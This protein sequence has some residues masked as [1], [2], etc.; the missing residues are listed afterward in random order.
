MAMLE[1][2]DL[3]ASLGGDD[4]YA[5]Y[6]TLREAAP[7]HAFGDGM[8]GVTRYDDVYECLRDPATFSSELDLGT[9][10]DGVRIIIATDPPDHTRLRQLV[11]GPFRPAAIAALE[12]RVRAIAESLVDELVAAGERGDADLAAVVADALPVIVIAEMLGVPTDRRV[13]FRT[14]SDASLGLSDEMNEEEARA[15]MLEYFAEAVRE[16][17]Q[18]PRDDLITALVSGKE[19][20]TEEEVLWFCMTLLVAGNETTTNLIG[21]AVLAFFDHPDEAARVWAN[22]ALVPSAMEEVL[23]FDPPAQM[24]ARTV[25]RDATVAGQEIP[26]G[27]F[28]LL[29]LAS[30]NRDPAHYDDPDRFDVT[31]NPRDHMTFGNGVH[32]CLG[33]SLAR[34]EARLAFETLIE[35]VRDLRPNGTPERN[36]N[37]MLRGVKHLPVTFS[38][39]N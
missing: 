34:L 32:L 20:L 38:A 37:Q 5:H 35:R 19:Q 10:T 28:V 36:S 26:A 23:R 27:S 14:W 12:P 3:F 15:A 33:A 13:D 16:R 9:A 22:P 1:M 4:P 29:M 2:A 7:V 17:R 11:T 31:R 8:F 21:N 24:V 25:K 39:V 6:S 18:S 30:A